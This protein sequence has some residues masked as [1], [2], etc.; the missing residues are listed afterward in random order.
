MM[1]NEK[2]TLHLWPEKEKDLQGQPSDISVRGEKEIDIR[3]TEVNSPTL[4]FYPVNRKDPGPAVLV[5]PGGGYGILAINKE[6]VEIVEWL[7][8]IG[9][10]AILLKYTVPKNREAA[11]NDIQ[12][13]MGLIRNNSENWNI[14]PGKL[15]VMGF[16][17]G[18]HLSAR[19]SN[20]FDRRTYTQV[21]E[22]DSKSC[23]PDFTILIYPAYLE[24]MEVSG[25]SPETFVLQ[26]KDDKPY[27]DG[28]EE[29]I[30][31]LKKQNIPA[32]SHLFEEG[33]HGYGMRETGKP[34]SDWPELCAN[35]LQKIINK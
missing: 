27:I 14:D 11:L 16:S 13:A 20:S 15:G 35:W 7:N 1:V 30:E 22:A 19:L 18:A 5:C 6:G 24:N 34:V 33:G 9:I 4:T 17:A 25:D 29:Y 23:R 31:G 10:N 8:S 3:I 21:D 12:R 28:T 32:E 26:T 2:L